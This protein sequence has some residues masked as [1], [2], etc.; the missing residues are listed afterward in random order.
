MSRRPQWIGTVICLAALQFL[1]G[2]GGG[3]SGGGPAPTPPPP[4][5]QMAITDS[6]IL[7]GALQNHPYSVTLHA[8]NGVGALTWSI[9]PIASTPF[10]DGLK[11]D[12]GSGVISGDANFAGSA[13]FTAT[14]KDSSSPSR[15]V[16]KNF[17]ITASGPLQAPP[18]QDFSVGQFDPVFL[19]LYANDGVPP[20]SFRVTGGTFPEGLRLT[21]NTG[22]ISGGALAVGTFV[23]TVT[24]Q[25]SYTPPEVVTTQVT[26]QVTARSLSIANSVPQQILLNRPFSGRIIANGGTPPYTFA[27]VGGSLPPGLSAIDPSSGQFNGT[28]TTLGDYSFDVNVTDS[29]NTPQTVGASFFISVK[30]PL[31]RNDSIATATAI[32]DGTFAASLSPYIDPPDGAPLAP[33]NDYYK[34]VSK[35]GAI[36]RIE[37][38]AQSLSVNDPM[39]SVLEIVDGSGTRLATCQLPGEISTNFTS[40]CISDDRRDLGTLDSA[41]DFKVPGAANTATTFYVH[42]LDWRGDARPDMQYFLQVSGVVPP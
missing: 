14:V 39:N 9:A 22:Q 20:L 16:S 17:S 12:A 3:S 6:S 25:D 28:P 40:A 29:S 26:I 4:A 36:I 38:Q 30:T 41:L 35:S 15:S 24:I 21:G 1:A 19:F 10:V 42:V 31:G 18:P 23:S 13:S 34:L 32:G 11:I 7:P 2:C 33:D 27:T 8:S 5:L 37:T